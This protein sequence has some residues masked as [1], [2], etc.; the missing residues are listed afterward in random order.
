MSEQ[1][2]A[3][4]IRYGQ[5]SAT[6]AEGH[7]NYW[8]DVSS[9]AEILSYMLE[10]GYHTHFGKRVNMSTIKVAQY[11]EKFGEPRVYVILACDDLVQEFYKEYVAQKEKANQS[12]Q[13]YLDGKPVGDPRLGEDL[14]KRLNKERFESGEYPLEVMD[15]EEFSEERWK[16]DMRWF[17]QKYLQLLKLVPQYRSIILG[18]ASWRDYLHETVEEMDANLNRQRDSSLKYAKTEERKKEILQRHKEDR[19]LIM[20][21]CGFEDEKEELND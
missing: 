1:N 6:L 12:Y 11:K 19:Q 2:K 14:L 5:W 16:E 13:D 10:G 15:Y 18:G 4:Q 17:R 20:E 8:N 7:E 9:L 3:E 21:V